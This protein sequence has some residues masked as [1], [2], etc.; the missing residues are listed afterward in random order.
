[1]RFILRTVVCAAVSFL[2]VIPGVRAATNELFA[3]AQPPIIRSWGTEAGLPQNTVTAIVQS[4]DGYMWLGTRDG[5]ARFDGVRFKTFGLESGLPSVDIS[6]LCEDHRG[7]L[8]IGT[9]GA[10]LCCLRQ[11]RI[12]IMSDPGRQPGSDTITCLQEDSTGRLW[13]GTGGGLRFCQDGK[14]V[15]ESAFAELPHKSI[16]CLLRSR[17]GTTMWIAST[18]YGLMSWRD[19]RLEP[20]VGPAGY[21]RI[22]A[23]TLFEDRQGRLWVSIG[24]GM[25]LCREKN[26]WRIF[27][28]TNG[29]PFAYISTLTEDADGTIWAGSL[30]DGLYRFDGASF[31]VLRRADGL[32]A[33]DIRSLYC[34]HEGNLWVGTRTGGLNRLSKRNLRVVAA[35]Q[36]LTNDFTRSVAETADGTLWAGTIGGSLYRGNLSGLQPFRPDPVGQLVYFYASVDSVLAMPDGSLWWGASGA[37]FQWKD[38]HLAGAFTNQPWLQSVSATALQDDHRGGIWI[39][40]A[41]GQLV[42]LQNGRF[43]EFPK[44]LTRAA[45]TSL[46][47]EP[48][49]S[50]WVGTVAAG[51]KHIREGSDTVLAVTN[52]LSSISIRTLHLD[53]NGTLWIGTAG[54]GLSCW[55][56][57]Q[58]INFTTS[59][60]LT[61]RTV[62]QIVEDDHG[63]LWLGCN[64]GIFKVNKRNLLDCADGK[65]SFVHSR[66]FGIND[67]MLAD[68]CSGGFCPAGLKTKSGLICISTVRGLVFLNPNEQ[69]DE[70]AP[71]KVLLEEMLVNGRRQTFTTGG[72]DASNQSPRLVIAPGNHDIELHFTAIE[73]S[74]PEKIGFRYK[75]EG[76]DAPKATGR[77]RS[78]VARLIINTFCRANTRFMFKPATP[79]ASG[80]T[81]TP[82]S[83]SA[84]CPFSGKPPG[85]AR[86]ASLPCPVVLPAFSGGGCGGATSSG[87]PACKRSTQLNANGCAF[88]RTCTTTWAA[89]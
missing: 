42:H 11:G 72:V 7:V 68:E 79:A 18:V 22:V 34:D 17:D 53:G 30:D 4:Q 47:V 81:K 38:D 36:G 26:Q 37:V 61:M 88:P 76:L 66:S 15:E 44:Q 62:S 27:N 23:Q 12:E 19:G 85:S 50:L 63:F 8:W 13:V 87:W 14:L 10:G 51:V 55:R 70:T 65:L 64:S 45:I 16:R 80:A 86:P 78:P 24:N 48:D 5:L 20:C 31:N 69:R 84:P 32:S 43:T 49:G 40:T 1:M 58:V 28:E 41:G 71:P 57:N 46:A 54:G 21:E 75:L 52:G 67:G 59:Q 73:F 39:G 74:A 6:S 56:N 33:E 77:R 3:L 60:G 83:R 9:Y 29:L 82:R 2:A 35:A 89:C 25:V